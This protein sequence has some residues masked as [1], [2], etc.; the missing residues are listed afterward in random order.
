M[1]N[2]KMEIQKYT[3][4]LISK[5]EEIIILDYLQLNFP[6]LQFYFDLLYILHYNIEILQIILNLN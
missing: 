2:K 6:H 5:N 3:E 1:N 4:E